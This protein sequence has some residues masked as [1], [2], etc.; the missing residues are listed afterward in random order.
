ME[1]DIV[2]FLYRYMQ[3]IK[4]KINDLKGQK[5]CYEKLIGSATE[6][7][8]KLEN[9]YNI[10]L[11]QFHFLKSKFYMLSIITFGLYYR[12]KKYDYE[13]R[14]ELLNSVLDDYDYKYDNV[15]NCLSIYEQEVDNCELKKEKYKMY[16]NQ[17][18]M[19]IECVNSMT[20]SEKE[21]ILNMR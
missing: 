15:V 14:M 2:R 11:K 9:S 1:N 19:F 10:F 18:E 21:K 8:Q 7:K 4:I 5:A 17:I 6:D 12:S 16:L 13:L 20:D 3:D